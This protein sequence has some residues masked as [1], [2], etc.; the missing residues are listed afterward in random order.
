MREA[1]H[2]S[3]CLWSGAPRRRISFDDG[4]GD[5]GTHVAHDDKF[6]DQAIK[7]AGAEEPDYVKEVVV[8]ADICGAGREE[9]V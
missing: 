2:I 6:G 7:D 1:T 9:A 3:F 5:Y 4:A 8:D